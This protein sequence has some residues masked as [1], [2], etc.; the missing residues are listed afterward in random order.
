MLFIIPSATTLPS[1]KTMDISSILPFRF[2]FSP[3]I[4]P[5]ANVPIG[6]IGDLPVAKRL[7]AAA[8]VTPVAL[9]G[10]QP[11]FLSLT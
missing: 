9:S 5:I 8:S 2:G 1:V 3:T 11:A 4:E 10:K 6:R 7:Y